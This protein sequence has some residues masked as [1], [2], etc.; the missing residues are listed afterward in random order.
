[1]HLNKAVRGE[2]GQSSLIKARHTLTEPRSWLDL[3][4]RFKGWV[5]LLLAIVCI[6]VTVASVSKYRD[7]GLLEQNGAWT[8]A[9]IVSRWTE[10][11]DDGTDYYAEF[12]YSVEGQVYKHRRNVGRSYYVA[13]HKGDTV[14]IQYLPNRPKLFEFV[15]GSTRSSARSLQFVALAV[16]LVALAMLWFPGKKAAKAVNARR[17]G[18]RDVA[19]ITRIVERTTSGKPTGKGYMQ[20]QHPD[21]LKGES[22]DHPIRKLQALGTGTEIVVFVHGDDIWWEGD[23]GPR[24]DLPSPLPK[25]PLS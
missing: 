23:I 14:S 7:A 21:G 5:S 20:F 13:H 9:A 24:T 10:S 6:I 22:L 12:Q 17:Y 8:T 11:D 19:T 16:G 3:F 18:R 1:M 25:V 15:E 2:K 4:L